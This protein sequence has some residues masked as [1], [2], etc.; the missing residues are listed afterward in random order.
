MSMEGQKFYPDHEATAGDLVRLAEEYRAAA[1][2]LQ[3]CRRK[4]KPLSSWPYRMVAIHAIELYLSAYLRFQGQTAEEVRNLQHNLAQRSA[5]AANCGLKL[6]KLT[7]SHL[8]TMTKTKEYQI[9]R[10]EI[11]PPSTVSQL[12]RLES[13][14]REVS[15]KVEAAVSRK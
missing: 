15:E 12:N 14:L 11:E 2:T 7:A 4:G 5:R 10:Y 8:A 6:K 3:P 9:S 1:E 13:T